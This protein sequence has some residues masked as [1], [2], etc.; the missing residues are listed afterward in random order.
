VSE[1]TDGA[2][3]YSSLFVNGIADIGNPLCN[4]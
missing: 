3:A 1:K 4:C 2:R